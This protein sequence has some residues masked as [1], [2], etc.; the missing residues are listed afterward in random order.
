[1]I[2][3]FP[4]YMGYYALKKYRYEGTPAANDSNRNLLL[5]RDPSVD[6]LKTGH[7]EAA[8]YCLIATAKRDA[9]GVGPRRLLS[10]V[11]GASSE[12]AR[13]AESQKLLNWGYTAFDIIKLFEANQAVVSPNVWKGRNNTVKLG[14]PQAIVAA[15]PAGA[16]HRIQTQA[17]RPEPLVAPLLKGQVV[18]ALKISLDKQPL[19]DIPLTVLETVEQAGVLGRAWDA[20]RLWVR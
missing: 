10:I 16:A 3:D 17:A 14:R 7:T 1:L 20:V 8:G 19:M 6:G 11:L 9:P 2:R 13:A 5:F 4:D 18:G 12:N 15:I